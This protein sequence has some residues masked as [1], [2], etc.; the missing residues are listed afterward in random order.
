MPLLVC[1]LFL[2]CTVWR[3]RQLTCNL[4]RVIKKWP[5]TVFQYL[6]HRGSLRAGHQA[7]WL[8]VRTIFA[9]LVW[10][11]IG[12]L[13]FYVVVVVV[14]VVSFFPLIFYT[15]VQFKK[16]LPACEN[17]LPSYWK[18]L[19]NPCIQSSIFLFL[20][21]WF[22]SSVRPSFSISRIGK[23]SMIPPGLCRSLIKT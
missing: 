21:A 2:G 22:K 18:H 12:K 15:E 14:V 1:A 10:P 7:N 20:L 16:V 11:S 3:R 17:Q 6:L 8:A 19:W 23:F 4:F 13:S 5:P 9:C